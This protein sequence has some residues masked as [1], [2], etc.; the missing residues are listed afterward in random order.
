MREAYT[1]LII[2]YPFNI[3]LYS[4][5]DNNTFV[6]RLERNIIEEEES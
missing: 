2:Y 3:K 1:I 4:L 6:D 5:N